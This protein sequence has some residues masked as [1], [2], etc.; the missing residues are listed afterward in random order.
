[1]YWLHASRIM[2]SLYARCAALKKPGD[3]FVEFKIS[4]IVAVVTDKLTFRM[5]PGRIQRKTRCMGPYAGVDYNLTL[6]PLQSRLQ[7]IYPGLG[8]PMPQSTLSPSQGL[9]IWPLTSR[10]LTGRG[11]R[12]TG[13]LPSPDPKILSMSEN[14]YS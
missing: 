4:S 1:M 11:I 2:W 6:C 9:R 5:S 7:H 3:I 12:K 10:S 13:L 14:G 8:N